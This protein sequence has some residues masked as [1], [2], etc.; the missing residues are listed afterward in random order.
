[1]WTFI[2]EAVTETL[3]IALA[4]IQLS[5]TTPILGIALKSAIPGMRGMVEQCC[6]MPVS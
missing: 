3:V 2:N 6:W 1:M 5:N 4:V